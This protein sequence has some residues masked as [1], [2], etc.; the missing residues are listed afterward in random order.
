[1]NKGF[2]SNKNCFQ[3]TDLSLGQTK[4]NG[5]L[6]FHRGEMVSVKCWLKNSLQSIS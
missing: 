1:M 3:A 4:T 2:H 6:K 5:S